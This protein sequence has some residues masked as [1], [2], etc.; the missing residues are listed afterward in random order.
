MCPGPVGIRLVQGLLEAVTV[1]AVAFQNIGPA[2]A[3]KIAGNDMS[4]RTVGVVEHRLRRSSRRS[5]QCFEIGTGAHPAERDKTFRRTWVRFA[6]LE[7][8]GRQTGIARVANL[9]RTQQ[10]A[11]A[12]QAA[13]HRHAR[14]HIRLVRKGIFVDNRAGAGIKVGTGD[15]VLQAQALVDVT[16]GDIGGAFVRA[17]LEHEVHTGIVR[18]ARRRVAAPAD[19]QRLAFT[20]SRIVGVGV[21]DIV[22]HAIAARAQ[23]PAMRQVVG[24]AL[25]LEIAVG[26]VAIHRRAAILGLDF[27]SAPAIDDQRPDAGEGLEFGSVLSAIGPV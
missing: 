23:A 9:Y 3:V 1:D 24:T 13:V 26:R 10:A 14:H 20:G 7:L 21:A 12:A 5:C 22:A 19:R 11:T 25:R 16:A 8:G 15:D 4:H 2:V 17:R 6:V 18:L 27:E